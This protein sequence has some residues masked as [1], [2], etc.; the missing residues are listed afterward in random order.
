M[1]A[2]DGTVL[3]FDVD[4]QG[5]GTGG[6][7]AA[8][9]GG[10]LC[11]RGRQAAHPVGRQSGG[12]SIPVGH[13]PV[14]RGPK[15]R[16]PA[17]CRA[18]PRG[19]ASGFLWRSDETPHPIWHRSSR[20]RIGDYG[21]V[22]CRTFLPPVDCPWSW[23]QTRT[24]RCRVWSSRTIDRRCNGT[25]A[26]WCSPRPSRARRRAPVAVTPEEKKDSPIRTGT[27]RWSGPPCRTI[28][29]RRRGLNR[30]P[31]GSWPS[32]TCR[33]CTGLSPLL[34]AVRMQPGQWAQRPNT[35]S[36]Q[37]QSSTA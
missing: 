21:A 14:S 20:C 15:T 8:I 16:G 28:A 23:H 3:L 25:R 18:G 2:G 26:C 17:Q 4:N 9:S 37:S 6:R 34:G 27:A 33:R 13:G 24:C 19:R 1:M 22:S 7:G 30:R 35:R 10:P 29:S 5:A 31:A 12:L 32:C 11:P 36:A